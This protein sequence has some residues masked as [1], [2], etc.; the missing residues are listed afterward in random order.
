ML[1]LY[2]I[3]TVARF[4]IK[5]LRRSWFFRIFA[6]LSV[7]ILFW[8]DLAVLT[9]GEV[10]H[11][12][13]G[14]PAC[15]PYMNILLLNAAQAVIAVFLASDFLKRD[16]KLD[17]TEVIYMRN[18][19]NGDYVL[20]KTLGILV[21]FLFLNVVTLIIAA[22]FNIIASDVDLHLASYLY[23]PL[24]ISIPTL[25]FI[26]GLSFLFMVLIRNQA[27][28]FLVLLGYIATTLF[29]LGNKLHS[30]F[31][32]MAFRVPLMYSEF[33]GFGNVQEILIHRGIYFILGLG[34]IAATIRM[35][36]RLP[37]SLLMQRLSLIFAI[38]CIGFGVVLGG[39]YLSHI[40]SGNRLR[41]QMLALN[42]Q[43]VD[44]PRVSIQK[45]EI[46]L[47]HNNQVI[48]CHAKVVFQNSTDTAIDQ[49]IFNLNPDLNIQKIDGLD[50]QLNFNRDHHLIFV[51]PDKP[52][53][54]RSLDSLTIHYSGTIDEEACYLDVDSE[55]REQQY[56]VWMYNMDKRHAFITPDYVLLTPENRWYPSPGVSFS[57]KRPQERARDFIRFKLHVQTRDPLMPYSQ[58]N[59]TSHGKD[60]Y[61]FESQHLLPQL[62]LVIGN[63]E[64]RSIT[65]DS[66]EYN[67]LTM[68][69][70]DYFT[71]YFDQIGDTLSAL[72]KDMK[73]DFEN[74]L[75]LSYAYPRF[76]LVETPVQY[77]SFPRLWTENRETVQPEMVLLPERGM[78][79]PGADFRNSLRNENRRMERSNQVVTP[80][81]MQA[82]IFRRFV[83]STLVSSDM[84][85]RGDDDEMASIPHDFLVYPNYYAFVNY[86]HSEQWPLLHIALEAYL[87]KRM[88]NPM[89]QMRSRM[90]SGLS[91]DEKV[92]LALM[93][94]NLV[95][96]LADPD[97]SDLIHT[98]LKS[99]GNYLF[100]MLESELGTEPF[101]IF[102]NDLLKKFKFKSLDADHFLRMLQDQYQVDFKS[103]IEEWYSSRDLPG[104]FI[105]NITGYEV[106]DEDR[107]RYQVMF[108]VTNQ[109]DAEGLLVASFRM[110]GGGRGMGRGGGYFGMGG[111]GGAETVERIISVSANQS[112]VVGIVL[113]VMPR[114]MTINTMISQNLPSSINEMFEKFEL[115]RN[116]D[117]FDGE[118]LLDQPPVFTNAN[119][120]IV[121]NED[122]GFQAVNP[123]SQSL[124]KKLLNIT[125]K[126][127]EKYVGIRYWRPSAKW[128]ATTDSD[129]HG[130]LVK[131]AHFVRSGSG[132]KEVVWQAVLPRIG[133]YDVYCYNTTTRMMRGRG[134]GVG[135]RDGGGPG[136]DRQ[137][138]GSSG[139]YHYLVHHDDG[140]DEVLLDL[141][142]AEDGWNFLGT[143]Y[144]SSDTAK[145]E[146]TNESENR[147]VLADAVKWVIH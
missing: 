54:P 74:Q 121:D 138:G 32:Y 75:E 17:T 33:T 93:E 126:E 104:F 103:R 38:V 69:D 115:K 29:F 23:Y 21:V 13:R 47:D 70:H 110:G 34:F 81:E 43:W 41:D 107:K 142:N 120:I 146:L 64:K 12:I 63:Y 44:T 49:Y 91:D 100:T 76:S 59:M 9:I 106:L 62:S 27:V 5:T 109:G 45:E 98:V 101:N 125:H 55:S 87:S 135:P 73:Q 144:I 78:M 72:I 89:A 46:T 35:L 99:K 28:T 113:D 85:G 116:I 123:E 16:K 147:I 119:E 122:P 24:L 66:I 40:R 84:R 39:I 79:M 61:T 36:K 67:L 114:F 57:P 56:R 11:T 30:L 20:G 25:V 80:A 133:N 71:S 86:I 117:P 83:T 139:Q 31:D 18:M 127:E 4:E 96:L 68:K 60:S 145:V 102:L 124:L 6:G 95:E 48:E 111:P 26:F 14:I 140:I 108:T 3:W 7:F 82:R 65:I 105:S 90:F 52:L 137:R 134:G 141:Q 143:F 132:D 22:I 118:R 97:K 77:I 1:S 129:Y 10:P 94:K 37:Q 92:N 128:Q 51:K 130:G 2:N 131:S 50:D 15:I 88:E 42:D 112:K 58:G 8:F 53:A 136:G 19:C